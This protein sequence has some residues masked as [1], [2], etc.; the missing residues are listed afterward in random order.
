MHRKT[1]KQRRQGHLYA[2]SMIEQL[3]PRQ[4]L[5]TFNAPATNDS[6]SIFNSGS[7]THVVINGVDNATTD[8][9]IIVNGNNGN[10]TVSVSSMLDTSFII[11][12]GGSGNDTVQN[13]VFDIDGVFDG[14][15]F[16]NGDVGIDTFQVDNSADSTTGAS[17]R[18]ESDRLNVQPSS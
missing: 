4:L 18:I 13:T 5:A 6:I 17:Y 8:T 2:R 1:Q 16:F 12:A 9:L 11:I 14:D 7:T 15:F 3:E 10:D